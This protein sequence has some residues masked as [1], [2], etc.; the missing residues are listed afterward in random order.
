MWGVSQFLRSGSRIYSAPTV[1]RKRGKEYFSLEKEL[2]ISKNTSLQVSV[3][4]SFAMGAILQQ[5][6]TEYRLFSGLVEVHKVE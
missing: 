2:L 4:H 5:R 3:F 1:I 6:R